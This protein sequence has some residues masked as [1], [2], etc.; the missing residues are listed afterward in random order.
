MN[1]EKQREL[2]NICLAGW[3]LSS[4]QIVRYLKPYKLII[5]QG[6][7][8]FVEFSNTINEITSQTTAFDDVLKICL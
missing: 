1:L 3:R 5:Y 6:L 7:N 4:T 8:S 2:S